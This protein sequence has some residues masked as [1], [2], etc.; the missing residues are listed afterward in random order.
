[1]PELPEVETVRRGME[2]FL[3]PSVVAAAETRS[4]GLRVP[5]PRGLEAALTGRRIVKYARRGKYIVL[6][7]DNGRA[8]ILHLGMSGRV[9][10]IPP[11]APFRPG[12]HDHLVLTFRN[13]A[14]LALNDPRRFGLVLLA[15]ESGLKDHKAFAKMGPEPL[16]SAFTG[17]KLRNTLMKRT[18]SI[19][20]AL[21]DQSVVAGLGNIYVCESLFHARI[22]P[23]RRACDLGAAESEKLA[24]AIRIVLKR[25]IAAGGST[26]R[27]YR[28]ADGR[29]GYFQHD[30]AVYGRAGLRCP[31]CICG[32]G[33]G[34]I[35]IVQNG[36]STFYCER[37]QK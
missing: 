28:Q 22:S 36:R 1:M 10:L 29:S 13:G 19:K 8:A 16:S 27:D 23:L 2:K 31:G 26:L 5:F 34:I 30:F 4:R 25:A 3:G 11:G 35:R 6:H 18:V 12:R 17:K 33:G 7:M 20:A 24:A 21:M 9:V 14:R 15:E 37:R 32:K